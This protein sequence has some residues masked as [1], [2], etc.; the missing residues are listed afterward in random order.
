MNFIKKRNRIGW[1][2]GKSPW[3]SWRLG[4]YG[5]QNEYID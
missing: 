2:S 1:Q 5:M 3:R 4:G